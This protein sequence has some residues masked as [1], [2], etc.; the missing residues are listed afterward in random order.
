MTENMGPKLVGEKVLV[1]VG[2]EVLE[3]P[4]P[5]K[6]DPEAMFKEL[7]NL[8]KRVMRQRKELKRFNTQL[9]IKQNSYYSGYKAH[10]YDELRHKLNQTLGYRTVSDIEA[11]RYVQPEIKLSWW[12]KLWK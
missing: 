9:S 6:P 11:G 4:K 5:T 3:W 7:A 1:P 8:R 10:M 12:Q 2:T